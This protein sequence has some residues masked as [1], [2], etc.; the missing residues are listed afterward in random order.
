MFQLT[1][2]S[3]HFILRLYVVGHMVE[4]HSDNEK[5]NCCHHYTGYSFRLAA[6]DLLYAL[7][8]RRDS[9]YNGLCYTSCGALAGMDFHLHTD[10]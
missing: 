7:S 2:H 6:K 5:E 9:T 3:R 1:I 8:H 4:D 10:T